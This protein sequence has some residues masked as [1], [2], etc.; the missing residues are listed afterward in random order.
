MKDVAIINASQDTD[1]IYMDIFYTYKA[2]L[3]TGFKVEWYQ[4]ID[5]GH[6]Q[7]FF[8]GGTKIK[9]IYLPSLYV[10]RGVNR[11]IV[12]GRRIP[13]L[14]GKTVLISD[15]TLLNTSKKLENAWVKVHDLRTLTEY[16]DKFLTKLM[17]KH[18]LPK[19]SKV[20]KILVTSEQMKHEIESR[21]IDEGRVTVLYNAIPVEFSKVNASIHIERSIEKITKQKVVDVLY[22]AQDRPYKNINFFLEIV[23]H[24][25]VT[26]S[27][28]RIRYHLVSAVKGKTERLIRS[29]DLKNLEVHSNLKDL[30]NLYDNSDILLYPSLY[31]GFGRPLVEAMSYGIPVIAHNIQP[32]IEITD[33]ASKLVGV[34]DLQSW[35]ESILYLL[36]PESY[37]EYGLRSWKRS[38][39]FSWDLFKERVKTVFT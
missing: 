33:G 12:F 23:R 32:I 3:E 6:E 25:P 27:D 5:P 8:W 37:R 38:K 30:N 28:I 20:E 35:K 4:C 18:M 31:E 16:S 19:L 34:N 9:G 26:T 7:H 22:V 39:Y 1:G 11:L 24:L 29:L 2:L 17:F 13:N 15:I 36:N 14:S 21:G 10:E